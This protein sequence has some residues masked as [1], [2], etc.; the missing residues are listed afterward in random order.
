MGGKWGDNQNY[1]LAFQVPIDEAFSLVCVAAQK[2]GKI[3]M[4]NETLGLLQFSSKSK[5]LRNPVD[6]SINVAPNGENGSIVK[7]A[8]TSSDGTVGTNAIGRAYEDFVSF[9]ADASANAATSNASQAETATPK[10]KHG[11]LSSVLVV[12][13]A[14]ILIGFFGSL[15]DNDKTS[16]DGQSQEDTATQ[17]KP[18]ALTAGDT[19]E[20][21]NIIVTLNSVKTNKGGQYIS[22]EDGNVFVVCS[23][24]IEN[25]TNEDL[26]ISSLLSFEAY[27]DDYKVSISIPAMSSS[28]EIQLD[29]SVASGKK[30]SGVVGYEVPEDWETFEIS[31]SPGIWSSSKITFVV[32][33]D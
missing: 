22:P 24:E 30:M 29:G 21:K 2:S 31:Y 26:A 10:K 27:A 3:T 18:T 8:A 7:I 11:C 23:F 17:N 9:I 13:G 25:Q 12:A 14:L 4:Q 1:E 33:R 20:L 32:P 6:F 16:G 19:A 5:G 28:S 15:G